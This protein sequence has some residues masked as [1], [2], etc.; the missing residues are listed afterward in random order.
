M[1]IKNSVSFWKNKPHPKAKVQVKKGDSA[2]NDEYQERDII[3][4]LLLYGD[5]PLKGEEEETTIG[6]YILSSI[7]EAISAFDNKL[8]ARIA[9]EYG[10]ALADG[11]TLN[12][13]HFLQHSDPEIAG[14]TVEF[15]A[16][17]YEYSDNWQKM[18]DIRLQTQPMPDAN[19]QQDSMQALHR[20]FLRKYKKMSET[21]LQQIKAFQESGNEEDL[22][23]HLQVQ[24]MLIERRNEIANKLNTVIL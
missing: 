15:C 6:Q 12:T 5:R 3:R 17:P 2:T 20:F 21:N 8:Y 7:Q 24:N 16:S 19:E 22:L 10:L 23:K 1:N 11:K 4:V 9:T 18:W 14:L 13:N